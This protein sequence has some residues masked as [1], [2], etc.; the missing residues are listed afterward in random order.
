MTHSRTQVFANLLYNVGCRILWR[1]YSQS[2][3]T[4]NK[5]KFPRFSRISYDFLGFRRISYDF[6]GFSRISVWYPIYSHPGGWLVPFGKQQVMSLAQDSCSRKCS[7]LEY[8]GPYRKH[9]MTKIFGSV[10][11]RG[12]HR[13]F[14]QK[15]IYGSNF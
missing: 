8:R 13:F 15:S 9:F 2:S 14:L 12:P 5:T 11:Y 10:S 1:F 3:R 6:L 7:I 4:E